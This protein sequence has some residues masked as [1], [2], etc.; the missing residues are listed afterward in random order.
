MRCNY[1]FF[2]YSE[3]NTCPACEFIKGSPPDELFYLYPGTVIG[4]RYVVGKTLGAG[5][6]GIVYKAWDNFLNKAVA[7]KE[8][9]PSGLVMRT[10][11]SAQIRLV[12]KNR[13]AE[14]LAGRARFNSECKGTMD[15]SATY[16]YNPAIV[17][18][19]FAFDD[20]G[21]AY[22]AMEFVEGPTLTEYV[23]KNG[24]MNLEAG[25]GIIFGI[26]G[27]IKDIHELGIIHRDI[28][29]DNIILL[30]EGG[31]KLI[32]FGAGKFGKDD[33]TIDAERIM[34]P[35]FSPPEQYEPKERSGVYTDIYS[36]G[37]TL[38]FVLTGLKPEE[39]TNRKDK[40]LLAS[41]ISLVDTIPEY[42]SDA[43][44]K[45]MAVDLRLRFKNAT[46]FLKALS[47]EKKALRPEVELRGRKKRRL[48]TVAA[49]FLVFVIA[50]VISGFVIYSQLDTLRPASFYLWI[51][52]T[53]D[54]DIDLQ[55]LNAFNDL[56]DRFT[57]HFGRVEITL[58]QIPYAEY[59]HR[60]QEA[61][62]QRTPVLFESDMFAPGEL[63]DAINLNSV[64]DRVGDVAHFLYLEGYREF[65]IPGGVQF[66][67]GF[68]TSAIYVNP[69]MTDFRGGN[70]TELAEL[71]TGVAV[72]ENSLA[73]FQRLFGVSP[74]PQEYF[75]YQAAGVGAL[76]ATT[77]DIE[78]VRAAFVGFG[79]A[80][81]D[82]ESVPVHM[83]GFFSAT[84]SSTNEQ[85]AKLRFL[86]EMISSAAQNRLYLQNPTGVLPLNRYQLEQFSATVVGF[87]VFFDDFARFVIQREE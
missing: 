37:A 47:G 40:D 45:A 3:G 63:S 42:V 74:Q 14:F 30:P 65:V 54:E 44:L 84:N 77:A 23:E 24:P 15:I 79:L 46:E 59:A 76:F 32:D 48:T 11:G 71:G 81:I 85:A 12:A 69:A 52:E 66:P 58:V 1:C 60:V 8:Y 43:I 64:A 51:V 21:T 70:I 2:E 27:A 20:Y 80:G 62:S 9:Y 73:D 36:V 72:H 19:V 75:F 4:G 49:T 50:G 68:V 28:S 7:I 57:N 39:S 83:R 82:R 17:H 25:L 53:G 78:L 22:L 10:P 31:A 6:F 41:P 18:D 34:K 35:G 5:G 13:E 87:S 16:P 26:L 67:T 56:I 61:L 55:R 38:Y 33:K 86:Q 29:P